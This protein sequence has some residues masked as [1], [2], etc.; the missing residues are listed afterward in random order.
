MLSRPLLTSLCPCPIDHTCNTVSHTNTHTCEH[1]VCVV[2]KPA[3]L[4]GVKNVSNLLIH[5]GHRGCITHAGVV[6][7]ALGHITTPRVGKGRATVILFGQAVVV[8]RE[9]GRD[10]ETEREMGERQTD[11]D[12]DRDRDRQRQTETDR[13]RPRTCVFGGR[14]ADV[15]KSRYHCA[16]AKHDTIHSTIHSTAHIT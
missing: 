2:E 1:N 10:R 8:Q 7:V 13:E 12:R 3:V 4:E 15:K 14:Q 16:H 9:G 5:K 6:A 11:R